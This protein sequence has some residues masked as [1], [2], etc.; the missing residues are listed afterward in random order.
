MNDSLADG[1][2]AILR[3]IETGQISAEEAAALLD[4]LE[5]VDEIET[6]LPGATVEEEAWML[7]ALLQVTE[8]IASPQPA[9]DSLEDMMQR[10]VRVVPLLAGVDRC[11]VYL[12]DG[13]ARPLAPCAW[14]PRGDG[15]APPVVAGNGA[16]TEAL[17][18]GQPLILNN[19]A[20][21]HAVL[22]MT[23]Q[24]RPLGVMQVDYTD[25]AHQFTPK[26]TAILANVA[27]QAAVGVE[28][29]RL[30]QEAVE[31]ARLE[32]ELQLAANVQSRLLQTEPPA[33]AGWDIAAVWRAARSV[34]GD[35]YDF[36]PLG[37][38][39][40][41]I[42]IAD[43]SG[44][45]LPAALFMMLSRSIVR[46]CATRGGRPASTLTRANRLI[47]ADAHDGM[48]V[49]LFYAELD[50]H[51]GALT[52]ANAGHNPPLLA[53]ANGVAVV[54]GHGRALGIQMPWAAPEQRRSLRC[55]DVLVLYTDGVTE[56][57][58]DRQEQFGMARLQAVVQQYAALPSQ[59]IAARIMQAVDDFAGN[60][61][62]FDDATLVIARRV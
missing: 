20:A 61:P 51:S 49:T 27:S 1:K 47:C 15:A 7:T 2:L 12:G 4:A 53:S 32:R 62:A 37:Q 33:L 6:T 57:I 11:A 29:M 55:G 43:V 19:A 8:A 46:A 45:G 31:R 25:A 36:V 38:D 34:G 56:A 9:Q 10:V 48:F 50:A 18:G 23:A 40:L 35:F 54:E 16:L 24:G 39:R 17:A 5:P 41:G 44:K 3:M 26:E 60:Q 13:S 28:N 58:N 14:Y 21:V 42:V 59:Q 52:S 30:R 22:P